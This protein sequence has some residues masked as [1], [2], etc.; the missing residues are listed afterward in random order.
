MVVLGVL[1]APLEEG[2]FASLLVVQTLVLPGLGLNGSFPGFSLSPS[3]CLE[4]GLLGSAVLLPFWALPPVVWL[5]FFVLVCPYCPVLPVVLFFGSLGGSAL[6]APPCV[7]SCCWRVSVLSAGF[8]P[9]AVRPLRPCLLVPCLGP[10]LSGLRAKDS[11]SGLWPCP[12]SDWVLVLSRHPF[13]LAFPRVLCWP[14]GFL[15]GQLNVVAPCGRF[16]F[17]SLSTMCHV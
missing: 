2:V 17:C 7:A 4:C 8:W 9:V 5:S 14:A 1:G 15:V 6:V 11:G 16:P 13:R 12:Y 3:V 10:F